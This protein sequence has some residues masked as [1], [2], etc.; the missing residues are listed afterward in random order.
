MKNARDDT[1]MKKFMDDLAAVDFDD[2]EDDFRG[3]T[4][5]A[6]Q[7]EKYQAIVRALL[8]AQDKSGGKIL[9][10]D[11]LDSPDPLSRFAAAMIVMP[12]AFW[13]DGEVKEAMIL[14]ASLC[15]RIAVTTSGD[16]VRASFTVDTIWKEDDNHAH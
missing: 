1:D 6:V 4:V 16:K 13:F 15:D 10:I 12:S 11:H 5:D 2:S 8:T 9:K 3:V 14:A 7:W